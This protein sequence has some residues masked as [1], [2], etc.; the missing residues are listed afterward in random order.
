[1]YSRNINILIL[2]TLGSF[3][4]AFFY[5]IGHISFI[6]NYRQNIVEHYYEEISVQDILVYSFSLFSFFAPFPLFLLGLGRGL[7]PLYIAGLFATILVVFF[8][9]FFMVQMNLCHFEP[10]L[11]LFSQ[12]SDPLSW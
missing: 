10:F 11:F 3:L 5:Y 2:I 12:F 4:S 9:V 1:M 6:E 8:P 7:H